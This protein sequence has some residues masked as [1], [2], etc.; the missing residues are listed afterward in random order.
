MLMTF[1]HEIGHHYD[2]TFRI[3]R[4]KWRGDKRDNLEI[5]AESMQH[6][7]LTEYVIP[8]LQDKYASEV[9]VLN[10][11]IEKQVGIPIPLE[12]LAGD[13]R[14]TAKNGCIRI[15][16]WF[17]SADSFLLF[18]KDISR[19][20]DLDEARYDYADALHQDEK[21]DY[22]WRILD[23]LLVQH[24]DHPACLNLKADICVHLEQFEKAVQYAEQ[25]LSIYID[26]VEPYDVLSNAYAGLKMW[27]KV[28]AVTDKILTLLER[29][30]IWERIRALTD[31]ANAY[32][33]MGNLEEAEKVVRQLE[34]GPKM[35]QRWA[36]RLRDK[37]NTK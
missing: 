30:D 27:E 10:A 4:D 2:F 22:A 1:V 33:G 8:F 25:V 16:S 12:L 29:D 21:Y 11:W 28:L 17:D 35:G 26:N 32:I 3:G 14:S 6:R 9:R 36:K 18:V 34:E 19:G 24:P 23:Q 7:W 15:S 31:R 5:Y 37:L 20:K 13:P